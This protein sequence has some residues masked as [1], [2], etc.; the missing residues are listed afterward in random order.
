MN[1]GQPRILICDPIHDDGLALLRQHT[2]VDIRPG[3]KREELEA[4]VGDYDALVV[5]SATKV[6]A[7]VIE[8]GHKLRAVGRAGSGLDGIDIAAARA[9][10]IEVL[11]C[12]DANSLAVAEHAFAL[13]LALARRIVSADDS[14]KAGRWE[15]SKL[16][17]LGLAG[18]SLGIVGFGRIGRQ[19]AKRAQAFGMRVIVNQPRFTPELALE[20]GVEHSDLS[21]LLR[22]A[23][24]VTLHVPL[25]PETRGLL[26]EHEL[27]L[28]KPTAYLINT[29]RGEMVDEAALLAALDGGRLAG[30]AL[31]VFAQEPVVDHTLVS[32]PKVIATPHIAASTEDAQ[33]TAA[34]QIA[35]QLL[36]LLRRQRAA[37]TLAVRFVALDQVVPHEAH[38]AQRVAK[39]ASRIEADGR[40]SNPPVVVE[41]GEHYVV[42][43]GATRVQ[44]LKQAGYRDSVVQVVSSNDAHLQ[45]NT[46]NHVI[47]GESIADLLAVLRDVPGLQMIE[48]APE[49]L[50]DKMKS[51]RALAS[52]Y[53]A[54][55]RGYLL[56][57]A[58]HDAD[59]WLAVLNETVARYI[60]WGTVDRTLVTEMTALKAQ[61]PKVV[62]LA[63][64]PQFNLEQ[65]LHLATEHKVVPAGITRFIIPGRVLRLH[66]PLDMLRSDE[67]LDSKND[68]LDQIIQEKLANRRLRY[69]QEPVVLLDE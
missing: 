63:V 18:K 67:P 2:A 16:L 52:L 42:L 11:N 46:W 33:R 48:T 23:D 5:R 7:S 41:W 53:T 50:H 59:G 62:A 44:A 47:S 40:L 66:V 31:D 24:F 38:D 36:A 69:Y 61:F 17:G 12:P 51:E 56:Q 20:F 28:M 9:R 37:D 68:W 34:M 49:Y 14:M 27:A 39:L 4:I 64:F 29:A 26:G 13:M 3:L 35:E 65:V 43:D 30:A 1:A 60:G 25:R 10:G 58:A 15:K 8:H 21:N 57:S 45:A 6:P 22:E 55:K 19:I 32:H 54:D